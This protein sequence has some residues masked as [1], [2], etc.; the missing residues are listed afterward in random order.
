MAFKFIDLCCG[1]GGFHQAMHA[2][3]GE[4][5]L[6]A[7]IDPR[8]R[9]VYKLNYGLT[10]VGAIE[11]I[12]EKTLPEYDVLCAGFPCQSF[13]I[14]GNMLG[15]AEPRGMVFFEILRLIKHSMPKVVLLENVKTLVSHDSGNTF[16][17]IIDSLEALGYTVN[18]RII[19]SADYGAA[20][21]RS[22]I[23]IVAHKGKFDFPKATGTRLT[24][25][26]F[27]ER[28]Y[29]PKVVQKRAFTCNTASVAAIEGA[30]TGIPL[31]PVRL[32]HK[33]D[34]TPT[35]AGQGNRVYSIKGV[36]VT[37]ASGG[38]G[39]GG[40]TGLYWDN[41]VVRKL[42]PMEAARIMGFPPTFKLPKSTT[43]AYHQ[44]GNAVQV[45]TV[46]L[47]A[48]AIF[49]QLLSAPTVLGT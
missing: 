26:S 22:R 25:E 13:S 18:H 14:S 47:I 45:D 2:F 24:V 35:C 11:D 7:D 39:L 37:F 44:V 19:N 32:G 27:L 34:T 23:Y 33:D 20:T 1:I 5:V 4:C 6:A 12:D 28:P 21:A 30:M 40:K 10:P 8:A 41:G 16:K 15:F 9:E 42:A 38:G 3:G 36:A 49:T 43:T 31:A 29:S 48:G 46:K 17:K